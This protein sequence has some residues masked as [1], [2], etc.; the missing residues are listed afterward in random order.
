M[1]DWIKQAVKDWLLG[2]TFFVDLER[3]RE[4]SRRVEMEVWW[5][6]QITHLSDRAARQQDMRGLLTPETR[7][8]DFA[9]WPKPGCISWVKEGFSHDPNVPFPEGSTQS[10]LRRLQAAEQELSFWTGV[11]PSKYVSKSDITHYIE[12]TK[13]DIQA[14]KKLL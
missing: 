12:K 2:P 8:K 10:A 13:T 6:Q 11:E 4:K 7:E 5:L 9:K 1:I 3:F 14:L